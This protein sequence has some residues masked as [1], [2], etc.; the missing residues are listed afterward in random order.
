MVGPCDLGFHED[1]QCALVLFLEFIQKGPDFGDKEEGDVLRLEN[2]ISSVETSKAIILSGLT[3]PMLTPLV[4]S[5][6][7][8][9]WESPLQ[10][11]H[12]H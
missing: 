8:C 3:F 6:L 7:R 5:C 11:H 10:H 9:H 12:Y 2:Q 1:K 4:G